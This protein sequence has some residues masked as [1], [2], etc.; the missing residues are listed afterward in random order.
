MEL[1]SALVS[2]LC[3]EDQISRKLVRLH[4]DNENAYS[5]LKKS[6]SS[7]DLRQNSWQR[8]NME[9][10]QQS[11]KCAPYG[12]HLRITLQPTRSLEEKCLTG[13]EVMGYVKDCHSTT[14]RS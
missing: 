5:W 8:G 7:D 10:K 13:Y 3:F 4:I 2:I 9:N 12:S 11:V 1:L 14:W 6:R